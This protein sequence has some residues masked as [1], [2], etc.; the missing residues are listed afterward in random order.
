M[1]PVEGAG[2]LG[3]P[4]GGCDN[5]QGVLVEVQHRSDSTIR[6][7]VGTPG[8]PPDAAR[9]MPEVGRWDRTRS[10]P[11]GLGT[12]ERESGGR[13]RARK[14]VPG[15]VALEVLLPEE[16]LDD[17]LFAEGVEAASL[18]ELPEEVSFVPDESPP[19]D[20]AS[21][22]VPF[23]DPEPSDPESDELLVDEAF[24][25]ER[26]SAEDPWSFL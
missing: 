16:L 3:H 26:P 20:D 18:V 1:T 2:D 17:A 4:V 5:G 12:P 15:Q 25:E 13:G 21:E 8:G 9:A 10:P 6:R 24:S 11:G 7:A 23:E 22:E 19:D 14:G